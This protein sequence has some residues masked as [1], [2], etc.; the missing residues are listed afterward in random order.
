MKFD[1]KSFNPQAFGHYVKRIPN[2]TKTELAKSGAVGRNENAA[3]ALA[4]QT[5]SLYARIPFFGRI[6]GKT[7]QNNDG[8]TNIS[9]TNTTTYEQGFI[10]ASRMDAWTERSFSKNI[11]A[12]V[13]FMN[14][15]AAQIAEY[16]QE[17]KQEILLAIL[18]GIFAMKTVGHTVAAKAAREF[19]KK[20]VYDISGG[21]GDAAKVGA[22][23]LNEAI[24]K[25][26]GDN[27]NIFKLVIM[28]S[29]VAT[30]LENLRLIKYMQYTDK[31]GV[32][33]DLA[34]ATWNGRLVL[35]DDGMPVG[36]VETTAGVYKAKI[37]TK[38][39]VGD[40]IKI[41][42]VALVAGTDFS[43]STDTATGNATAIAAALNAM[44]DECISCYTWSNDGTKL[45]AT[46]D[47]GH[48]GEGIFAVEVVQGGSGTLVVDDPEE[49][50]PAAID[51]TYTT[52]IL[53]EGAII[54]DDIGDSVPYEMSR[55]PKTNGGQDTLYV[56]DRFVIGVDGISFEK[57]AGLTASAS[58]NDLENG[59][60]WNI[61]NDGTNY[62]PVKSIAIAKIISK[63]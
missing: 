45:V 34:L 54:L 42:D 61:I 7:S 14:N 62:I 63:G 32:Q 26:C 18:K 41:N 1:S 58:N 21:V 51:N 16:K 56:R 2:V 47:S 33:R 8:A 27:K 12:G 28:H 53:G 9:S 36:T 43:L 35:I 24:Q 3:A 19:L 20:H 30:N 44:D 52:Y 25:A 39:A 31:D 40:V 59:A 50:T 15:V 46:E 10:T 55:D 17:V 38:A 60:N 11:T 29:V 37:S 13:D 57:P 49:T 22:A 6:S 5:G 23:T 4:N 48:F